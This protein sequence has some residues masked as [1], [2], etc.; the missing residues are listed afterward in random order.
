MEDRPHWTPESVRVI[1]RTNGTAAPL[2][3]RPNPLRR[4]RWVDMGDLYPGHQLL[5]RFNPSKRGVAPLPESASEIDR[6]KYGL[7]RMVLAHR[8]HF[9][10]EPDTPWI[11]PDTD[12]PLPSP[13]TDEFWD[14]LTQELFNI[15]MGHIGAEAKKVMGSIEKTSGLSIEALQAGGLPSPTGTPN[16]SSP[17]AGSADPRTSTWTIPTSNWSLT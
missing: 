12:Q 4:E 1:E 9:D 13:S 14:L 17:A 5:I 15:L 11:D 16:G 3:E 7:K 6:V 2:R 10:G 8:V